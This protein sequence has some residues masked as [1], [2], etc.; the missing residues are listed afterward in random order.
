[1]CLQVS[2]YVYVYMRACLYVC[3]CVRDVMYMHD[4]DYVNCVRLTLILWYLFVL[5]SSWC[6]FNLGHIA[7]VCACVS[8]TKLFFLKPMDI[9]S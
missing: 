2:M 5:A 9:A 7:L 1:M 8:L 4:P 3:T 6:F